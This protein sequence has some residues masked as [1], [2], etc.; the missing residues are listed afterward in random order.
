MSPY[1][2]YYIKILLNWVFIARLRFPN[3]KLP[4]QKCKPVSSQSHTQA[5]IFGA[6]VSHVRSQGSSIN[7]VVKILHIFDPPP[8]K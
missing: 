7:H 2:Y 6:R 1:N 5:V 8:L 4:P 3:H